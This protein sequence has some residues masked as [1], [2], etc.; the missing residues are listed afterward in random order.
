MLV[1]RSNRFGSTSTSSSGII[2]IIHKTSEPSFPKLVVNLNDIAS[3]T[4]SFSAIES[5]MPIILVTFSNSLA[6]IWLISPY[7]RLF[8]PLQQTARQSTHYYRNFCRTDPNCQDA[9]MIAPDRIQ[10][11]AL[12]FTVQLV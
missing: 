12:I 4:G 2:N 9:Q 6:D 8:S 7:Y 1:I 10:N 5:A 11:E 3:D